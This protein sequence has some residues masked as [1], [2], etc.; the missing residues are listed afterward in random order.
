MN[1][2]TA[3]AADI[4]QCAN[5]AAYSWFF[6]AVI[7]ACLLSIMLSAKRVFLASSADESNPAFTQGVPPHAY[8]ELIPNLHYLGECIRLSEL[9][10]D[11]LTS[12]IQSHEKKALAII[13][14]AAAAIGFILTKDWCHLPFDWLGFSSVGFYILSIFGAMFTLTTLRTGYSGTHPDYSISYHNALSSLEYPVEIGKDEK[15]EM[16]RCYLCLMMLERYREVINLSLATR[17]TKSQRL[18][19][20]AW[21]ALSGFICTIGWLLAKAHPIIF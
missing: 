9:M 15:K 14:G 8:S 17:G 4:F 19:F 2:A 21:S 13:A 1:S 3:S 11:E 5:D 7:L 16:E 12:I 6:W 20:A 10:I 18:S